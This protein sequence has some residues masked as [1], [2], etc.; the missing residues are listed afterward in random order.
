MESSKESAST[1]DFISDQ[2]SESSYF[3]LNLSPSPERR[4]T[5]TCGGVEHCNPDYEIH[6]DRFEYYGME[7]IA[8]GICRL[9]IE[10]ATYDL[11]AGS[12]FCYSPKSRVRIVNS[13]NK[14]LIKFFIDFDGPDVEQVIGDPFLKTSV[15]YRMPNLRTM[16]VIFDQMIEFGQQ[17]GRG[18]QRILEQQLRLVS[19]LARFK[20]VDHSHFGSHSYDTYVRCL[21]HVEQNYVSI[22]SVNQLADECC[23]SAGHLSRLFSKFADESPWQMIIRLKMNLAGELLLRRSGMIKSV[24]S[25]V[26]F[27]DAYH[28]SRLFKQYYGIAPKH[29]LESMRRPHS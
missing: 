11:S 24:A 18:C 25:R 23:L 3:F 27:D 1:P 12:I 5:V 2:V 10:D 14:P 22:K 9:Q 4:F 29:F 15:P 16:H 28:F 26:G 20:A 19:L 7:Y 21:R 13:G 6:R 8:S 17:G